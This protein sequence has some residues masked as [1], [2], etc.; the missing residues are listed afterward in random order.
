MSNFYEQ[1]GLPPITPSKQKG[2]KKH[3]QIHKDYKKHK[4]YRMSFIKPNDCYAKKETYF[5]KL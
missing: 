3:D 1:Y 4:K 2:K 5:K